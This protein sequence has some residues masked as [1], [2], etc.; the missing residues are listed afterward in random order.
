M[1]IYWLAF[2]RVLVTGATGALGPATVTA[3]ATAGFDVRALTRGASVPVQAGIESCVGDVTDRR[4]LSR[5]V[6]G[7]DAV[8]HLA[9]L[10]HIVNPPPEMR[11][12]YQR[13]NVDGTRWLAE[14]A[15][16]AG[17]RRFVLASTA[18]VYG[19]TPTP[20]T[21]ST[22][23]APD[24][25]YAETKLAAENVVL[26]AHQP[27]EFDVTVLRLS[28]VY[29]ARIKGNYQRLLQALAA[30]RFVP[31]GPGVNRRSLVHEDDVAAAFAT[32]TA[33]P[34]AAGRLFN[35]SDGTPHQ[36][37]DIVRSMCLALGR[38]EPAISIPLGPATAGVRALEGLARLIG[39]TPPVTT[40]T[41][42]KYLEESVVD[43]SRLADELG[44]T[45]RIGLDDGWR[46]TVETLR[47]SGQLP[48]KVGR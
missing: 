13:I 3:L 47:A 32:A 4:S 24:S 37:R 6:Q 42:A 22:T 45:A 39:R 19:P 5:A 20:A 9:A 11:A 38:A 12:A 46:I 43:A 2:V 7:M 33:H 1:G 36:I 44:F 14:E 10:L 8:V 34:A 23:P 25:L 40:A 35:V 29:G 41:L 31:L 17:V 27:G 26:T 18:A 15:M 28:A 30:G 21:E 48:A 16:Q